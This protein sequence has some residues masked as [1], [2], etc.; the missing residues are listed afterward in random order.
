MKKPKWQKPKLIVIV[1]GGME[2]GV[3]TACKFD[4]Q[5]GTPLTDDA[6]CL[7]IAAC[8]ACQNSAPS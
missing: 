7:A 4:V 8:E 5:G 1:R 2:E 6:V 3:L